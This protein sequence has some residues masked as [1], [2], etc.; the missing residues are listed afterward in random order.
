MIKKRGRE[1]ERNIE[2]EKEGGREEDREKKGGKGGSEMGR[3]D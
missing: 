1:E 3:E 2:R